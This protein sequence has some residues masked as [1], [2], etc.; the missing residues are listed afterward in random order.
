MTY[1]SSAD[2][3]QQPIAYSGDVSLKFRKGGSV[4][5]T[6]NLHNSGTMRLFAGL[7]NFIAGA[8]SALNSKLT[9][10][11]DIYIPQYLALGKE[12]TTT[13]TNPT[14]TRLYHE[15]NISRFKLDPPTIKVD[16]A[17]SSYKIIEQ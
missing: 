9:G 10:S 4:Y 8:Y 6:V 12:S 3:K 13:A 2:I 17:T 7:A 1:K 14:A 15:L 16:Y 11:A 5:K